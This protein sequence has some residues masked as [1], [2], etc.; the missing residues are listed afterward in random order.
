MGA[1]ACLTSPGKRDGMVPSPGVST[2]ASALSFYVVLG[3]DRILKVMSD[4][5]GFYCIVARSDPEIVYVLIMKI[6][7]DSIAFTGM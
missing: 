6:D 1:S 2:V 7:I 3:A 4:L 5:I